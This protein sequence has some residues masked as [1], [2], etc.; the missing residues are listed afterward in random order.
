M[1]AIEANQIVLRS[2]GRLLATSLQLLRRACPHGVLHLQRPEC[3]V[4]RGGFEAFIACT[5]PRPFFHTSQNKLRQDRIERKLQ[6][7]AY[8]G[9]SW[10]ARPMGKSPMPTTCLPASSAGHTQRAWFVTLNARCLR[11]STS[12]LSTTLAW[13]LNCTITSFSFR[14]HTRELYP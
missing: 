14:L 10:N 2:V 4:A 3:F 1:V 13:S 6:K 12:L 11:I 7:S 8:V 9:P 5:A